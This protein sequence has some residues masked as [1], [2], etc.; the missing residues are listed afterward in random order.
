[1]STIQN[2]SPAVRRSASQ[3]VVREM[4]GSIAITAMWVAVVATAIV[5]P[6]IRSATALGDTTTVPAA[7]V[8]AFF[9]CIASWLVARHAFRRD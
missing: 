1:M 4:W 7:V 2:E 5:G 8:V 3:L 6:N 9:A